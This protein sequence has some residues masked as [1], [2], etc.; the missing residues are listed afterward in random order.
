M[1][2]KAINLVFW[3]C[4][5]LMIAALFTEIFF[6]LWIWGDPVEN[7]NILRNLKWEFPVNHI[8]SGRAT[9]TYTRDKW[10]FRG[11]VDTLAEIDILVIGG[12]TSDERYIDDSET[13]PQRLQQCLKKKGYS[14]K[15]ANA[16]IAGQTSLGHNANF[17]LWFPQ[18]KGLAPKYIVTFIGVN[19][20][21]ALKSRKIADD[22]T[23]FNEH[24]NSSTFG[25]IILQHIKMKSA[26]YRVFR[27][28]R[29]QIQAYQAGVAF[30]LGGD[31]TT[32]K[33]IL[34]DQMIEQNSSK[35]VELSSQLALAQYEE[36]RTVMAPHLA[37]YRD[38]LLK[39]GKN[40]RNLGAQPVFVTQ[41]WASYQRKGNRVS[42]DIETYF[43]QTLINSETMAYCSKENIQCFDFGSDV[44]LQTGDAYD[45]AHSTPQGSNKIAQ[46]I[47]KYWS[48]P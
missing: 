30:D 22:V 17:D 46:Y 33:S 31:K 44:V 6:G 47:C 40:I 8:Y 2:K 45:P 27:T 32:T 16:A 5:L 25:A 37:F 21:I 1:I 43:R 36:I 41:T 38:Q 7:L 15:I 11:G 48:L 34:M 23:I 14:Y 3:N 42:G 4:T 20:T 10:G 29:G 13:W 9:S 24:R 12:S 19:D 39:L 28:V 18:L 35:F 26:L